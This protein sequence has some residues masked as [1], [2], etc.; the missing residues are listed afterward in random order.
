MWYYDAIKKEYSE[1]EAHFYH[2]YSGLLRLREPFS[3][4][5][6]Q[7]PKSVFMRRKRGWAY[8][9]YPCDCRRNAVGYPN[10]MGSV[11]SEF[12][13]FQMLADPLGRFF[14]L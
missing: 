13:V 6:G 12:Q 5:K 3:G 7:V 4:R 11:I 8:G 1:V 14:Y 2:K 9:K 10:N